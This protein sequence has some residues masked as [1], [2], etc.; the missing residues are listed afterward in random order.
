MYLCNDS[1]I[2]YPI[3]FYIIYKMQ[4]YIIVLLLLI[5]GTSAQEL[6][7]VCTK[8]AHLDSKCFVSCRSEERTHYK[9]GDCHG[10]YYLAKHGNNYEVMVFHPLIPPQYINYIYGSAAILVCLLLLLGVRKIRRL[11]KAPSRHDIELGVLGYK[12][13]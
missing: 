11:M 5:L 4:S 6:L 1:R 10:T 13:E 3:I 12:I 8:H 7:D 9:I 2:D